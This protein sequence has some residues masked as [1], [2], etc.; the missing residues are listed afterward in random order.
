MQALFVSLDGV[1]GCGKSTQI[2]LLKC[3]FERLG[4]PALVVRDPGG[5]RL[6]ESLREILLQRIDIPIATT[7][8]MLVYMASR[9]QLVEELIAPALCAGQPVISDRFLLANVVYQ[10][11]A[12]GLD[13]EE[14]W[15]VGA[16]ATRGRTPNL[17]ILLDIDPEIAFQRIP[18]TRDRLESRGLNYMRKVREGFLVQGP[19]LAD[20]F[21]VVDASGTVQEIHQTIVQL[22]TQALAGQEL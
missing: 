9:A 20:R 7:A 22:V 14:I 18:G 10:G 4:Q 8:E 1:D 13:P 21:K 16:I 6:G 5:T 3:W 11:C 17:T 2:D 19:R 15:K 12:G